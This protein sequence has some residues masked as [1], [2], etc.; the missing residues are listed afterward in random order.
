M[1]DLPESG[2]CRD[3][4]IKRF[5]DR[6]IFEIDDKETIDNLVG[7]LFCEAWVEMEGVMKDYWNHSFNTHEGGYNFLAEGSVTDRTFC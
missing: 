2:K 7:R 3:D 5:L 1:Q 6:G 4:T